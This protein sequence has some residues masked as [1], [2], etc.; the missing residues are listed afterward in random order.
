MLMVKNKNKRDEG[1]PY[2][3]YRN[4]VMKYDIA[5]DLIKTEAAFC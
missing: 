3:T 1:A 5:D 2:S 4:P